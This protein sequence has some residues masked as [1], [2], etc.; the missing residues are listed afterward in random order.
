MFKKHNGDTSIILK[1]L[2]YLSV[3]RFV[4]IGVKF[5]LVAYLIRVLGEM[6]YGI[7]TWSDAIVQFLII[8]VNFGFNIYAAKYIVEHKD[9]LEKK[10]EVIT[11]IF[12]I[13]LALLILSFLLLYILSF[14]E[15]FFAYRSILLLM[16]LFG[17]GEVFFPIW[18]F[19]G[20]EKLKEAMYIVV[21]SKLFL[22]LTTFIWVKDAQDLYVYI[23]LWVLANIVMG[24]IGYL[25]LVKKYQ[26]KPVFAEKEIVVSY[27]KE[28]FLFFVGLFLSLTFNLATIFLI[29]MYFSMDYVAGFDVA[30]KIV[31]VA[32]IPF[33]VL[34]QAVYPTIF[35][36]EDKKLLKRL[37][38]LSLIGGTALM[39][40]IYFFAEDL[41]GLFGGAEVVKYA[42]VLRIL[43]MIVPLASLTF[44]L[45]TSTLVAFGFAKE[46]NY[47]LIFS[48]IIFIVIV[49]ILRIS[50]HLTFWN[51]VYLRVISDV[52]LVAI[53]IFYVAQK[54]IL[55]G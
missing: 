47:S 9:N 40:F 42:E 37:I 15:P 43:S 8:I 52:I 32:I 12:S 19:Q 54:R 4:N 14:F 51:L 29:G 18:Y 16:L 3:V 39:L 53:R 23:V 48:A 26:F 28:A 24:L 36:N 33:D 11:S 21:F 7:L 27:L 45:G 35:R 38:L 31:L 34:Q 46:F 20:M 13:K 17:F 30:L 55:A 2:S 44:I 1:N 25:I 41:L 5:L 50:G 10:N 22:L 49:M 6:N